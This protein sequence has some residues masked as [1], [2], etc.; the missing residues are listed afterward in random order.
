[1]AISELFYGQR[2]RL[3]PVRDG[4]LRNL[5]T[6]KMEIAIKPILGLFSVEET[7]MR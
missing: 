5:V 6:L 3:Q 2:I 7:G 1:M 4:F